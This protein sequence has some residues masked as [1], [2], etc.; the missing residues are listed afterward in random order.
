MDSVERREFLKAALAGPWLGAPWG[1]N[2]TTGKALTAYEAARHYADPGPELHRRGVSRKFFNDSV[3]KLLDHNHYSSR[4]LMKNLDY[5]KEQGKTHGMYGGGLVGA[6]AGLAAGRLKGRMGLGSA[7]GGLLGAGMGRHMW[8][9]HRYDKA[10][11]HN[12]KMHGVHSI[13]KR[14]GVTNQHHLQRVAPLLTGT[15]PKIKQYL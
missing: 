14:H 1:G 11:Q 5:Q 10:K 6:G 15:P 7:I 3:D 2:P 9:N 12:I 8:G 4:N 13:L